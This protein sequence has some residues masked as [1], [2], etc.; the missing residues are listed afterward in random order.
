ML[1]ISFVSTFHR[2]Q[3][4]SM[5]KYLCFFHKAKIIKF[6]LEISLYIF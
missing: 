4:Y 2:K 1:T 3:I 6:K 5:I